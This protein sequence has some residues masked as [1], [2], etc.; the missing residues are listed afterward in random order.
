MMKNKKKD[1]KKKWYLFSIM[2]FVLIVFSLF[3]L[4]IETI[5]K[6][7]SGIEQRVE[8]SINI[9]EQN[10]NN[11]ELNT[12][13][14]PIIDIPSGEYFEDLSVN[15][16]YNL[17]DNIF[18]D[19]S[20]IIKYTLDGSEPTINSS[21]FRTPIIIDSAGETT[22]KTKLFVNNSYS[23]TTTETYN[24]IKFVSDPVITKVS[25][26]LFPTHKYAINIVSDTPDAQIVYS[27]NDGEYNIYD[28]VIPI[29][30]GSCSELIINA[31]ATKKPNWYSSNVVTTTIDFPVE[32]LPAPTASIQERLV[33]LNSLIPSA[34][35]RYTLDGSEP[36]ETS[37]IYTDSIEL[38]TL[39]NITLKVKSFLENW[40]PSE[41]LIENYN[42]EKVSTPTI[43]KQNVSLMYIYGA[44]IMGN[45]KIETETPNTTIKYSLGAS[46]FPDTPYDSEWVTVFNSQGINPGQVVVNAQ[47]YKDGF[48]ESDIITETLNFSPVAKVP[49]PTPNIN[50]G[51]YMDDQRNISL[52]TKWNIHTINSV[53]RYTLDGSEPTETSTMY[54]GQI[55]LPINQSVQLKA[56]A[57]K[58]GWLE[59]NTLTENYY[60]SDLP[61]INSNQGLI[62]I[63]PIKNNLKW[64]CL[65]ESINTSGS[66]AQNTANIIAA[67]DFAPAAQYCEYSNYGGYSDWYLPETNELIYLGEN[68]DSLVGY[69]LT[70]GVYWSSE[71]GNGPYGSPMN[72]YAKAVNIKSSA[73]FWDYNEVYQCGDSDCSRSNEYDV[74]CIR[75]NT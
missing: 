23:V 26:D 21:T 41:T 9:S 74:L 55:E 69:G 56:K 49:T 2:I 47:A 18:G 34:T 65:G 22:L 30:I 19:S 58:G 28:G 5:G 39:T 63:L 67:C 20:A 71:I 45:F 53:I 46:N 27:F 1:C 75:K 70:S 17:V 31:F 60:F 48:L 42:F 24:I 35:I 54:T 36:S 66:G 40:N 73:S 72:N 11:L 57:F 15:I 10:P 25:Y 50:S 59:S 33:T 7:I 44:N 29:E 68:K 64:G 12:L 32:T 13:P 38:P 8:R 4:N 16:N 3:F 61:L 14:A 51:L 37:L 6:A 52:I 62:F 43:T